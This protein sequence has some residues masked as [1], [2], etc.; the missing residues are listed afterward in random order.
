M[1]VP[2]MHSLKPDHRIAEAHCLKL[3]TLWYET[4]LVTEHV[5]RG[6]SMEIYHWTGFTIRIQREVP[7]SSHCL[8]ACQLVRSFW[9]GKHLGAIPDGGH[10]SMKSRVAL[11][12]VIIDTDT[13]Q[14]SDTI[15]A[16]VV[17]NGC[18]K[19]VLGTRVEQLRD[20]LISPSHPVRSGAEGDWVVAWPM[21]VHGGHDHLF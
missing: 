15:G 10:F 13:D 16:S 18:S 17:H 3:S 6:D 7:E 11:S 21:T 2:Q 4:T 5:L 12:S 1:L 14:L 9:I 8:A 20:C 19:G